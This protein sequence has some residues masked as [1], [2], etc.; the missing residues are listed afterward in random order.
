MKKL[1]ILLILISAKTYG[2][3]QDISST[4]ENVQKNQIGLIYKGFLP[5]DNPRAEIIK[6]SN[7][8]GIDYSRKIG[9]HS[10]VGLDI[11]YSQSKFF[12][13]NIGAGFFYQYNLNDPVDK[14]IPFIKTTV[15][16]QEAYSKSF[17]SQL[18]LDS[19]LRTSVNRTLVRKLKQI[20]SQS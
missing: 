14:L 3:D 15:G 10:L 18:F 7:N 11:Y 9:A 20:F 12:K 4:D 1:L 8:F 19:C 6:F 16:F 13:N 17:I 2:Q 5:Y